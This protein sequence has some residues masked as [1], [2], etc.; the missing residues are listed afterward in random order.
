MVSGLRRG[1]TDRG[2]DFGVPHAPSLQSGVLMSQITPDLIVDYLAGCARVP[3]PELDVV[4]AGRRRTGTADRRSADRRAAARATRA[5][6]ARRVLEIGTAIGYSGL[7]IATALPD[8][9]ML[10]TLERDE[11]RAADGAAALRR[12]RCRR[13][14]L[15]HG[16]R[17][18]PLPAQG[19]RPVRPDLPGRRQAAVRADAAATARPAAAGRHAR[20]RQRAVER[21]GRSRLRRAAETR[22]RVDDGAS[23]P[24]TGAW[25][26]T[27]GRSR[28]FCR[29]AT[30]SRSRR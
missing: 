20:H 24:T 18:E 27:T 21:R 6:G 11:E 16:R 12:G 7:W 13:P 3:H 9:G 26:A 10:I 15:R 14:C 29:S 2:D 22:R 19:R 5:I 1:G 4:A 25:P 8:E 30:A 28:R 17:R 23:P